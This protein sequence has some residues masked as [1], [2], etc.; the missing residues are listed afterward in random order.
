MIHY[1]QSY[2]WAHGEIE[3]CS[4][5]KEREVEAVCQPWVISYFIPKDIMKTA[6]KT[7]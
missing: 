1:L 6:M 7:K 2:I 3:E 5:R 4:K